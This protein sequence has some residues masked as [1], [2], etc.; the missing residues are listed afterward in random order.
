MNQLLSAAHL[1]AGDSQYHTRYPVAKVKFDDS[2]AVS[3]DHDKLAA[4]ATAAAEEEATPTL[5][6]LHHPD[7]INMRQE[8]ELGNADN[9]SLERRLCDA[10]TI[11]TARCSEVRCQVEGGCGGARFEACLSTAG[12]HRFC[13]GTGG[14]TVGFGRSTRERRYQEDTEQVRRASKLQAAADAAQLL[15]LMLLS[16]CCCCCATLCTMRASTTVCSRRRA[17]KACSGVGAIVFLCSQSGGVFRLPR[18]TAVF[19]SVERFCA[20]EAC[21][22]AILPV[23]YQCVT[24]IAT[25]SWPY[26][27]GRVELTISSWP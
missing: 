27:A 16:C 15:L 3:D 17:C 5:A 24:F 11:P 1:P 2:S 10:S 22:V 19:S 12:P 14:A 9:S 25:S 21:K 8:L 23:V 7:N 20:T 26:R 13:H 4:V 18:R 6:G